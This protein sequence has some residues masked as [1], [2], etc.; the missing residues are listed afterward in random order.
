MKE[1]NDS[2][3]MSSKEK[4]VI[5]VGTIQP[6]WANNAVIYELNTRQFSKA[7]NFAEVTNQL[8]R[9]K[10]L[11]IDIIWFM[12]IHPISDVKR[13]GTSGIFV[14]N[15]QDPEE[16]KLYQGSPYSIADYRKINPDFG[17]VKDFEIMVSKI[18]ELGMKIILDW[19]PNHTGWDHPWIKEHSDFYTK[20]DGKIIDPIDYNT[21]E[22]WGWTDVADLN[23]DNPKMRQAMIDDMKFWITERKIDGFRMDVAH[24][25][26]NDFWDD[27]AKQLRAAANGDLFLLAE[28]EVPEQRNSG[29]FA[30]DYGWS[31]HHLLNNIAKG[32]KTAADI[33]KWYEE[34]NRKFNRGY[35]MNFITNHDENTWAGTIKERMGKAEDALA[36]FVFTY[37]GMPLI[38]NGQE[39][40]LDKRL[41]FFEH[42]PIEWG[43]YNKTGF[44]KKLTGLKRSSKA[45][46]NGES[47]GKI[48]KISTSIPESIF[49]F[50]REKE[51]NVVIT[52]INMSKKEQNFDIELGEFSGSYSNVFEEGSIT[53]PKKMTLKMFPWEYLVFSR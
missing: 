3:T 47:G 39:A 6:K 18:H 52:I 8:P 1:T 27:C 20:V 40:S 13:K 36:V 28:G 21:G 49:A 35:H 51:D 19:V 16:R 37:E 7:G 32:K 5:P 2:A 34:D 33:D 29:A 30:A 41:A 12:P 23:Y 15:I 38:Y 24:G 46:A 17:T 22:S 10:D 42:D 14:N 50:A 45:L 31:L 26:P 53:L 43:N 9:L 48:Q 44:Y 11:G 25:V 4:T